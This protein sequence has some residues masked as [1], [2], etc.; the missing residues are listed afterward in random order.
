MSC[1]PVVPGNKTLI[2]TMSTDYSA[3]DCAGWLLDLARLMGVPPSSL[4]V[5]DL[6]PG[7]S[8]VGV[9]SNS[10]AQDAIVA[11]VASGAV[12]VPEA[13]TV[14]DLSTNRMVDIPQ[15]WPVIVIILLATAGALVLMVV[16]IMIIIVMR[17]QRTRDDK[18][19]FYTPLN[20]NTSP[21]PRLSSSSTA[22]VPMYPT[23][24][25]SRKKAA[26][27][28]VVHATSNLLENVLPL[29]VGDL[30]TALAEDW[31]ADGEWVWVSS[32]GS[33]GYYPREWM[34]LQ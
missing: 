12:V 24:T 18:S 32:G 7:S 29:K 2:W 9:A 10:G 21:G 31:A 15:P 4:L 33:E 8:I 34:R 25:T 26:R 20:E 22:S 17:R 16:I 14:L 6:R 19:R 23:A 1:C 13:V 3:F 30:C 28:V 11:S 5:C 27:L